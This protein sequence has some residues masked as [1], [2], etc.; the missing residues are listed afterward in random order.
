M[1]SSAAIAAEK[2]STCALWLFVKQFEKAIRARGRAL[3]SLKPD[4][5]EIVYALGGK[6]RKSKRTR[7]AVFSAAVYTY[8]ALLI[9]S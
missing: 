5:M 8:R 7:A 2:L 9:Y 6:K 3:K 1:K 4:W